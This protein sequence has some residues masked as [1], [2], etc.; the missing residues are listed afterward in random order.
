MFC[1][2]IVVFYSFLD[3]LPVVY[4][5]M[6]SEAATNATHNGPNNFSELLIDY[7]SRRGHSAPNRKKLMS[8][9]LFLPLNQFSISDC[10]YMSDN[11]QGQRLK[12]HF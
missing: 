10:V 8:K 3:C 7:W 12:H 1:K 4:I 11:G 2:D 6:F 9:Y 5:C